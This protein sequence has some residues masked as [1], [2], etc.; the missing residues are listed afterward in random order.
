MNSRTMS[1]KELGGDEPSFKLD[2]G[3]GIVLSF[4]ESV[5][6]NALD[7][8]A[9]AGRTLTEPELLNEF[10]QSISTLLGRDVT[11]S[12][13]DDQTQADDKDP[14]TFVFDANDPIRAQIEN[15]AFSLIIRTGLKQKDKQDI[16]T[17]IITIPLSLR[18]EG[19]QLLVERGSV[20]VA[21]VVKPKSFSLQIGR[22]GVIR[23]K[24]ESSI[25]DRQR[26]RKIS[27]IQ[28]GKEDLIVTITKIQALDGWLAVW[29]E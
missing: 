6:N 5:I 4:H 2:P 22:A 29:A 19:N 13:S 8:M 15:G 10:E 17:Q 7:R 11:L 16:P 1:P 21:P 18:I 25:Q 28:E 24:I 14:D 20:R 27:L 12:S 23:K 9:L 26:E 3:N